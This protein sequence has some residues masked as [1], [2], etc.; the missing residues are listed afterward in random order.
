MRK[1]RGTRSSVREYPQYLK[2]QPFELEHRALLE[3]PT[4]VLGQKRS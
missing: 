2:C 1:S 3:G 4:S